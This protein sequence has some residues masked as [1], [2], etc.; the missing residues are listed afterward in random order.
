[1]TNR[2]ADNIAG[3]ARTRG[4][5]CLTL[6]SLST[7]TAAWAALATATTTGTIRRRLTLSFGANADNSFAEK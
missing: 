5:A 2:I 6:K 7:R 1:M 3:V 4:G